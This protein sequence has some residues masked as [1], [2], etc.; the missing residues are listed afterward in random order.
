MNR[1]YRFGEYRVEPAARELWRGTQLLALPP[2]VFDFLAY[3]IE[4]HERA[5]GRDEVVAAGLQP[6]RQGS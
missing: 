6:G 1:S 5:V 3:L 4:R 2:Q